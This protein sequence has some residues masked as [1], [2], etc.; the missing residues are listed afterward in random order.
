ML[1]RGRAG[2]ARGCW[3]KARADLAGHHAGAPEVGP[4]TI[5]AGLA[6]WRGGGVSGCKAED[7]AGRLGVALRRT[8]GERSGDLE[9]GSR[10]AH[11][12]IFNE[13][14]KAPT[15]SDFLGTH[16]R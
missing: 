7:C 1:G 14:L 6:R 8:R 13:G 5:W 16:W 12:L 2:A 3:L 15:C 4:A 9:R 10:F 11:L